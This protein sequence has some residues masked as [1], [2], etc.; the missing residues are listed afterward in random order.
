MSGAVVAW[1]IAQVRWSGS[2]ESWA[3]VAAAVGIA[4]AGAGFAFVLTL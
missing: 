4:V 3:G 1:L 2:T